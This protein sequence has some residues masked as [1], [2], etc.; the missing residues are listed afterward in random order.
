MSTIQTALAALL[1]G[2]F[3][4][5]GLGGTGA[6][7]WQA[8]KY[9]V[10]ITR[11]EKEYGDE[12]NKQVSEIAAANAKTLKAERESKERV[13]EAES[14]YVAANDSLRSVQDRLNRLSA[15]YGSLYVKSASC[16]AG[17]GSP[18]IPSSSNPQRNSEA[19][20]GVCKLSGEF[21][22]SLIS[23]Y[24]DA[25]EMRARLTLCKEYAEEI[26]KFRK[27]YGARD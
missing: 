4:G 6:W 5:L 27:E 26:V 12:R 8:N 23:T 2:F 20:T 7:V 13:S 11:M 16:E 24:K 9:D 10:K 25:D 18:A 17:T 21:G 22:E 3:V 1:L 15:Q 14:K 19:S